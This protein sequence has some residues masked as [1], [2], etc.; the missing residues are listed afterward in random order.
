MKNIL[1]FAVFMLAQLSF[2]ASPSYSQFNGTQFTSNAL[3]VSVSSGAL[4]TN[5]VA[6]GSVFFKTTNQP[7]AYITNGLGGDPIFGSMGFFFRDDASGTYLQTVHMDNDSLSVLV[8]DFLANDLIISGASSLDN[9]LITSDGNG[10]LSVV[11]L[12]VNPGTIS[13]NAS[14]V[15]SVNSLSGIDWANVVGVVGNNNSD[16]YM[17]F[18]NDG[19]PHVTFDGSVLTNLNASSIGSGTVPLARLPNQV[20]NGVFFTGRTN[21]GSLATTLTIAIGH[22]MSSTNYCPSVSILGGAL[23]SSTTPSFSALTTTNF[24]LNLSVGITGGDNLAW[25]VSLSP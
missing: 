2:A 17:V 10:N 9:G 14:G 15:T 19:T 22:T 5:P 4:V 13:G 24:V 12:L 1:L 8:G 16:G 18:A 7:T 23:A 6:S 20:T 3:I 11:S 21:I 25:S